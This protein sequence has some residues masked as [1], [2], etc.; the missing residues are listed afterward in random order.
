[1]GVRLSADSPRART[2]ATLA[3]AGG[4]DYLSFALGD[5]RRTSAPTDRA[6]AAVEEAAIGRLMF[7]SGVPRIATSR[8]VDVETAEQLLAGGRAEAIG[9][10][11]ADRGSRAAR[12]GS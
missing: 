8:V 6:S 7:E 9:M 2:I 12:Q 10:T 4:A 5:R 1:V 11:R 3:E